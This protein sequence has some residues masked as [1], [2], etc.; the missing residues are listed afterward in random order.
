MPGFRMERKGDVR[1]CQGTVL[2]DWIAKGPDGQPRMNGT[3]VF[4]FG[5]DVRIES[6]TG[7][8]S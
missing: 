6:V 1:H 5:P 7:I 3:N 2:A 8:T 4:I